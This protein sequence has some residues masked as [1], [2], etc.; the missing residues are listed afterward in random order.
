MR[1]LNAYLLKIA[2]LENEEEK[3]LLDTVASISARENFHESEAKMADEN[4][5]SGVCVMF[6]S[7]ERKYALDNFIDDV[8]KTMGN[9][10]I[11][12]YKEI[13]NKI[14]YENDFSDYPFPSQKIERFIRENLTI[15]DVLDKINSIGVQNLTEIDR[16]VLSQ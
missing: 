11:L 4:E 12:E 2:R 13:T 7:Q 3:M 5:E 8:T 10:T 9:N 6:L 16:C 14:L 1:G 15:D